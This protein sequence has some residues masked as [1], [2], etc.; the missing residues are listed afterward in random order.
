[1]MAETN[2]KPRIL[3][4]DDDLSLAKILAATLEKTG[5]ETRMVGTGKDALEIMINQQTDSLPD[6]ALI[7]IRLPDI[8][9]LEVLKET[10]KFSPD[11]G[12]IMMTGFSST[13]TA[14]AS[15]NEG[16]FSYIQKP[17]HI[18]EVKAMIKKVL[19]KQRLVRENRAL[20]LRLQEW[21]ANLERTVQEKTRELQSKNMDLLKVVEELKTADELKSRFVANAS[22][23]LQ[24]PM[25]SIFG[26]SSMLLQHPDKISQKNMF[27]YLKIIQEESQRST[28]LVKDLLDLSRLGD[29]QIQLESKEIDLKVIAESAAK[30]IKKLKK[31]IKIELHFESNAR[32]IIS[33]PNKIEQVFNNLLMNALKYSKGYKKIKIVAKRKGN[34]LVISVIDNGIGIPVDQREKIFEPFYR[35]EDGKSPIVRGSGLGLSICKAIIQTLNGA[36]RVEGEYG[37]GSNFTF[38]LPTG[39]DNDHE[40]EEIKK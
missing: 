2:F 4:V 5:Y 17:Y 29:R 14:I 7:D 15:L 21:N 13:E 19:E 40:S 34:I 38:I 18:D 33:D 12:T 31:R 1:M 20:T 22:H 28:R 37:K 35:I 24:T 26:F 11:T 9:G 3:I 23:E 8:G 25:T 30:N 36:I 10:K 27:R 39:Y 32:K 6:V 16:A